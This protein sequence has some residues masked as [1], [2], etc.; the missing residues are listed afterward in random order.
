M[1]SSSA[2]KALFDFLSG[3]DHVLIFCYV[4]YAD[5]VAPNR[6]FELSVYML[7]SLMCPNLGS[8]ISVGWLCRMLIFLVESV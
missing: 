7:M 5:P 4:L 2:L 6:N 1:T 8:T 3:I